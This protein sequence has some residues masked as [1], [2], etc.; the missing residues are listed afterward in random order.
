MASWGHISAP[1]QFFHVHCIL[2]YNTIRFL[3]SFPEIDKKNELLRIKTKPA[4]LVSGTEFRLKLLMNSAA[5]CFSDKILTGNYEMQIE[6]PLCIVISH[7]EA[8]EAFY[9]S[10]IHNN[11]SLK[12]L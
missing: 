12:K 9:K 10:F 2:E 6:D 3:R 8:L 5:S 1:C 11:D 7:V 4:A